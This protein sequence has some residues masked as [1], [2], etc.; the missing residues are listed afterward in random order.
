MDDFINS[1]EKK[2]LKFDKESIERDLTRREK[3]EKENPKYDIY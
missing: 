1:L 2:L 3:K